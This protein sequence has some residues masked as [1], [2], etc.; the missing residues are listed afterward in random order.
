MRQILSSVWQ[1]RDN[2]IPCLWNQYQSMAQTASKVTMKRYWYTN[3]REMELSDLLFGRCRCCKWWWWL[4]DH[5]GNS[6]KLS[7][8]FFL[9]WVMLFLWCLSLSCLSVSSS[10]LSW[11]WWVMRFLSWWRRRHLWSLSL[12]FLLIQFFDGL[13]LFLEFHSSILEPD[14]DL[15]LS[16]TQ[17]MS[18]FNSSPSCEVMIGME[19][20]LQLK[21]LVSSVSLSSSSSQSMC[22]CQ[23][24]R[25]QDVCVGDNEWQEIL[26]QLR[27]PKSYRVRLERDSKEYRAIRISKE[28]EKYIIFVIPWFSF[29]RK[30]VCISEAGQNPS[31]FNSHFVFSFLVFYRL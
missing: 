7:I 9:W 15:S 27:I 29:Q 3:E 16:Q 17:G 24:Y 14:L 22:T 11:L 5:E 20:F 25:Y 19:L 18:H 26:N 13:N 30:S 31:G 4:D 1:K 21:G 12:S 28:S 8:F 2:E 23:T 6:L 10:S